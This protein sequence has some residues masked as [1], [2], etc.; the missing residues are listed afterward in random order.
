MRFCKVLCLFTITRFYDP[1]NRKKPKENAGQARVF[2]GIKCYSSVAMFSYTSTSVMNIQP[3]LV[4]SN[5]T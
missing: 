5:L 2:K 4:I 3:A 1:P